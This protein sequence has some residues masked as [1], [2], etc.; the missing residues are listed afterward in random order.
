MLARGA[1][2]PDQALFCSQGLSGP[3]RACQGLSRPPSASPGLLPESFPETPDTGIS[4]RSSSLS[5]TVTERFLAFPRPFLNVFKPRPDRFQASFPDRFSRVSQRLP[6]LPDR[7]WRFSGL[8]QTI[9]ERFRTF[10]GP[11]P[12]VFQLPGVLLSAFGR[13][14][15]AWS[16]AQ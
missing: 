15:F 8:S 9:S 6:A 3:L 5:Q 7:F 14:P 2:A 12:S 1:L 16:T 10:A 13:L 11:F 4:D